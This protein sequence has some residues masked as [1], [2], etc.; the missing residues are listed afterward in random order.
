M[1]CGKYGCKGITEYY[2]ET[3]A[4]I[5]IPRCDWNTARV[6]RRPACLVVMFPKSSFTVSFAVS[7][8]AQ[9]LISGFLPRVLCNVMLALVLAQSEL[10]TVMLFQDTLTSTYLY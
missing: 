10:I 1:R 4:H 2:L 6:P 5:T 8:D 9:V 3:L 7:S